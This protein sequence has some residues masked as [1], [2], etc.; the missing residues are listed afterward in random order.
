MTKTNIQL[1]GHCQMCG[2]E[3]AVTSGRMAHHGY[4]VE[5]GYFQGVCSGHQHSPI[6]HDRTVADKVVRDVRK[7]AEEL[8]A[9]AARYESGESNPAFGF[10]MTCPRKT[11]VKVPF[12]D[13][14]E[15]RQR[16]VRTGEIWRA[17]SQAKAATEF[18]TFLN[19]MADTFHGKQLAEVERTKGPAPILPGERRK[20]PNGEIAKVRYADKGRVYWDYPTKRGF[21]TGSQAWRKYELVEV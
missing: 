6:E 7:Q 3:Q 4:T 14:P 19:G 1:R 15:H 20:L 9:R 13:L 10:L 17:R 5:S 16:D 18:A 2:R 8:L 11:D 12:E 21:W